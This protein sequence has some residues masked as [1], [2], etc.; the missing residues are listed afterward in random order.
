[1]KSAC[2]VVNFERKRKVS[3]PPAKVPFC[4]LCIVVISYGNIILIF[5]TSD[6]IITTHCLCYTALHLDVVYTVYQ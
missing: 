1:M 5:Q 6:K 2:W 3:C 4:L